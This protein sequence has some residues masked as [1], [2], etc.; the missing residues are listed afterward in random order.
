MLWVHHP[1]ALWEW[2]TIFAQPSC[3]LSLYALNIVFSTINCCKKET[4]CSIKILPACRSLKHSR[5]DPA[6]FVY[7]KYNTY[8]G[9]QAPNLHFANRFKYAVKR[10]VCIMRTHQTVDH[11]AILRSVPAALP[12]L[13]PKCF[14]GRRTS[15]SVTVFFSVD[16]RIYFFPEMTNMAVDVI[17]NT[18]WKGMFL[19]NDV[20]LYK[21]S[22]SCKLDWFWALALYFFTWYYNMK[23]LNKIFDP[24]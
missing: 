18:L 23:K 4:N 7:Y 14:A 8:N 12:L 2:C 5:E 20:N 15:L 9:A 1:E 17:N 21:L 19:P 3:C 6:F 24:I 22:L 16:S 13:T 10:W 11:W